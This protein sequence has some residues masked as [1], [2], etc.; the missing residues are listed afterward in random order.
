MGS[1][2]DGVGRVV[3]FRMVL[4][5]NFVEGC[6]PWVEGSFVEISVLDT[7]TDWKIGSE[8]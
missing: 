6:G 3:G 8:I 1:L 2:A 5:S 4:S 7:V